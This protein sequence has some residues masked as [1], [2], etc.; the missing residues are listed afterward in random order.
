MV[1]SLTKRI[2]FIFHINMDPSVADKLSTLAAK[3][4]SF[5]RID[6]DMIPFREISPGQMAGVLALVC[7]R[8]DVETAT[9]AKALAPKSSRMN[10]SAVFSACDVPDGLLLTPEGASSLLMFIHTISPD[11]VHQFLNRKW[12]VL[13]LQTDLVAA[14]ATS[15]NLAAYG[16][17]R[18]INQGPL[19]NHPLNFR[20]LIV[21]VLD[22]VCREPPSEIV[23][24]TFLGTH[25]KFVP[26]LFL[27]GGMYMQEP[28]PRILER[29]LINLFAIYFT[30]IQ[31]VELPALA[32]IKALNPQFLYTACL[33]LYA[34]D[35]DQ[36]D[37]IALTAHALGLVDTWLDNPAKANY[38]FTLELIACL[39]RLGLGSAK[40]MLVN[41]FVTLGPDAV[42]AL[43]YFMEVKI[44]AVTSPQPSL[45]HNILTLRTVAAF[46]TLTASIDVSPD[47]TDQLRAIQIQCLQ[48][49]PRLINF[50]QGHDEAILANNDLPTFPPDVEQEMKLWFQKMYEQQ[51]EIRDVISMLER[52]KNSDVPRDQDLFAC[53]THSLFDEYRFFPEYPVNALATTAVLFGSL[54][55]FRLIDN[56][57]LSV[58]LRFILESLRQPVES[59]MFRFGLQALFELRQRLPEFPKYCSV[60]LSIPGLVSQQQFYQQIKDIVYVSSSL[61]QVEEDNAFKSVSANVGTLTGSFEKPSEL[62]KDKVLFVVNNLSPTNVKSKSKELIALLDQ[63]FHGW[64]SNY[65]VGER[66]ITEPNY[67]ALYI[68]MLSTIN[69]KNLVLH[70]CHVLYLYVISILNHPD[71]LSQEKRTE[72]KNLG[73]F[74]GQL[75]LANNRPVLHDNINFKLLLAEAVQFEKVAAV[76]P[77]VCKILDKAADSKVFAPPNAWLMGIMSVL[78]ELYSFGNLKLNLKFEIEVLCNSLGLK[79]E[80]IEPSNYIRN[81]DAIK[82]ELEMSKMNLESVPA[83]SAANTA[84]PT[85]GQGLPS[86]TYPPSAVASP[87]PGFATTTAGPT[88]TA[89]PGF[90]SLPHQQ[91][92]AQAAAGAF[93]SASG[94]PP[95]SSTPGVNGTLGAPVQ[96][97]TG[98]QLVGNTD[99]VVHPT[100]RQIFELAISKTI[101]EV[102]LPVV[103]RSASIASF[104]TKELVTKDFALE[105]DEQKLQMAAHNLS[106]VLAMSMSLVTAKDPFVESLAADLRALMVSNGYGD[107]SALMEQIPIAARDNVDVI[108]PLVESAAREKAVADVDEALLPS[109]VLRQR[110][111]QQAGNND[112]SFV[113]QLQTSFPLHLPDPLALKTGGL[114]PQQ[115]AIYDEFNLI[116]EQPVFGTEHS[117]A[118]SGPGDEPTALLEQVV[119]QMHSGVEALE[120]LIKDS[121]EHSLSELDQNSRIMVLINQI[122]SV[123]TRSAVRDEV[124][125]KTSQIVVSAMFSSPTSKLGREVLCYL[126]GKLCELSNMTSKEVVLWLLY[127]DDE[128]KYNVQVMGTLIKAR[129]ISATEI[130]VNLSKEILER[131]DATINFAAGLILES[132]L[133]ST[134]YCLRSEFTGS[135]EAMEVIATEEPSNPVAKKVLEALQKARGN[136]WKTGDDPET[137]RNK[138]GYVFAEWT[139][140]VQRPGCTERALHIFVH[141]MSEQNLLSNIDPLYTLIRTAVEVSGESYTSFVR[142]NASVS[143]MFVG[144]DSLAKLLITI[145]QTSKKLSLKDRLKYANGMFMVIYLL[146]AQEHEAH[147]QLFNG[148]LYFRFWSTLLFEISQ[149]DDQDTFWNEVLLLVGKI[150]GDL[151]PTVFPGFTTSWLSLISHRHFLNVL[152]ALPGKKGWPH[153][154]RLLISWFNFLSLYDKKPQ[155]EFTDLLYKGTVRI[156]SVILHDFPEFYVDNTFPLL[157]ALPVNFTQPRNV[158]LSAFPK[159]LD[160]PNPMAFSLQSK[161]DYSHQLPFDMDSVRSVLGA[162]AVSF[163]N[164]NLQNKPTLQGVNTILS[165]L[166]LPKRQ[167]DPGV[168]FTD[169]GVS[170]PG[171]NALAVYISNT[172]NAKTAVEEDTP[173]AILCTR[174]LQAANSEAR[175]FF[176]FAMVNQ[177]RYPSIPTQ[178]Y[179]MLLLDLFTS[180]GSAALKESASDVRQV[181]IRVL[182]ERVIC[183]RPHPWGLMSTFS[184]LLKNQQYKF[185]ELPFVKIAPEIEQMF[186]SLYTHI[187]QVGA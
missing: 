37:R 172:L 105:P 166:T 38:P 25:V 143:E 123:A 34:R 135:L 75:M 48:A 141:E 47:R 100:L 132:V 186:T 41:K 49:Y 184:Q 160:L 137:L 53:M 117:F 134:P 161:I 180:H 66:A 147:K 88:T 151:E 7:A 28:W 35:A 106:S 157:N 93:P 146:L 138:M 97:R 23:A 128:R 99:F 112:K 78:S 86:T 10:W 92:P 185:W 4:E 15:V 70:C 175:Y 44:A 65:I 19:A 139:R 125:L 102:L 76:V 58:A 164:Q 43:L 68:T 153:I 29:I 55:H 150:F 95:P 130:D 1:I 169:V 101:Q 144:V 32:Q 33:D 67:H 167:E 174:I 62:V 61:E 170:V 14:V 36:L 69:S 46:E 87:A 45:D 17:E 168:D 72:L 179:S 3:T 71:C 21:L 60:L 119:L 158:I 52:L 115:L 127:S 27:I 187:T 129:L 51:I 131:N 182:L 118:T 162:S 154:K 22:A 142:A 91:T 149:Q 90:P 110:F 85:T 163:V 84:P 165:T 176:V 133:G 64:F 13:S 57:P 111:H 79:I 56:I 2:A 120:N 74:L 59:N 8:P 104:T 178:F 148:Q 103:E 183:N 116:N 156:L 81:Q 12:N 63:R 140:L 6:T 114:L 121:H 77:F 108:I 109:Y 94:V 73:A 20:P 113:D 155:Q 173:Q 152:L 16:V 126:L 107:H 50:G 181:V 96:S 171:F 5:A 40:E 39:D 89:V 145:L 31:D 159:N 30:E 98:L 177:L 26:E 136:G 54:I 11:A 82:L 122:L 83:V 9:L 42:L 124:I 24:K 18:V 80:N